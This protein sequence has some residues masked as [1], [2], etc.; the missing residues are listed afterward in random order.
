MTAPLYD[1]ALTFDPIELEAD[2]TITSGDLTPERTLRTAILLSLFT[3]ARAPDS[4]SI[5]DR[6]RR[7]WWAN[8]YAETAGDSFGSLLWTLAREKS[9]AVVAAKAKQY[10]EQALAWMKSDGIAEKVE[11]TVELLP[12]APSQ[13]TKPVLAIR[14]ETFKPPDRLIA[15]QFRYVWENA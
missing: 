15:F 1:A 10:T 12:I 13:T 2:L 3:D 7:G 4:L 5:P 8:A 6:D 11:A 14:V 9:L